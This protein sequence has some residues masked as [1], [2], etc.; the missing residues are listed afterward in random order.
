MPRVYAP[1][2]YAP[3]VA[4]LETLPAEQGSA[5]L[6]FAGIEA[7]LG[8]P[9]PASAGNTRF[10]PGARGPAGAWRRVGFRSRLYRGER[11]VLFTRQGG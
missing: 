11:R 8:W 5:E 9:L 7:I 4:W 3:L 6:S 10:W 1:S 2:K